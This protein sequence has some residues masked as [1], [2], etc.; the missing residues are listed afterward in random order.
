[1]EGGLLP[2]QLLTNYTT[3]I[4]AMGNTMWNTILEDDKQKIM[5]FLENGGNIFINGKGMKWYL[6]EADIFLLD[7]IHARNLQPHSTT[8]T[9]YGIRGNPVV[10]DIDVTLNASWQFGEVESLDDAFPL[11]TY[12]TSRPDKNV[13]LAVETDSYKIVYFAFALEAIQ[14]SEDQKTIMNRILEWFDHNTYIQ[15]DMNDDVP[16]SFVLH[17]NYPNP[18]NGTTDIRYEISY[19]RYPSPIS[20]KIY[21]ILGQEMRTLVNEEQEPGQ[22]IITWDGRDNY[23]REVASGLYVY[24]LTNGTLQETKRMLLLK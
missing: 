6:Q 1:M 11:F 9:L 16:I 14:S 2:D 17:Q 5:N 8:R 24:H 20:L 19:N 12:D 4:W 13:A 23:G 22:Y 7:Y 15:E 10:G 3:V 21:N 18:F